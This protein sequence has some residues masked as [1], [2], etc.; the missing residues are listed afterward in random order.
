MAHYLLQI[1]YA[2]EQV[3][4]LVANPQDRTGEA[5]KL[6]EA[7]GGKLLHFFFAFGEYDAVALIEA[8]DNTGAAA[9]A[10]AVGAAGTTAKYKTTV[11]LTMDEAV[12]AMKKA[13][14][15]LGTYTPPAG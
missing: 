5:R 7:L 12:E 6:V 3:K 14:T 1:S 15:L 4:A 11:L 10:L 2:P 9:G 13:G 8:P